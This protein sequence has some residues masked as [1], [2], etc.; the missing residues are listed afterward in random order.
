VSKRTGA[1]EKEES[2]LFTGSGRFGPEAARSV[3]C[4]PELPRKMQDH[5]ISSFAFAPS[6]SHSVLSYSSRALPSHTARSCGDHPKFIMGA[7]FI[8][9]AEMCIFLRL[10]IL[11]LD[12][13]ITAVTC[14]TVPATDVSSS[15]RTCIE[16]PPTLLSQE[17]ND[18]DHDRDDRHAQ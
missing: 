14:G 18:Q 11:G 5:R 2:G 1:E 15:S 16:S 4:R 6:S 7:Q 3:R 8:I 13:S 10:M 9:E 12:H 17:L